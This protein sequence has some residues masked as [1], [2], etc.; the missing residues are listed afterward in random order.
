MNP[1]MTQ[2]TQM[3]F[4]RRTATYLQSPVS[5]LEPKLRGVER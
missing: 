5:S 3:K 2:M 1:Q 4:G